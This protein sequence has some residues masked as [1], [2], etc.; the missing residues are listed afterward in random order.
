MDQCKAK[1]PAPCL[2]AL[3]VDNNKGLC[4]CMKSDLDKGPRSTSA[5]DG[6]R[7]GLAVSAWLCLVTA[8]HL[9]QGSWLYV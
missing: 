1:V 7:Q 6:Q 9:D 4:S 2:M 8:V 3:L 5:L